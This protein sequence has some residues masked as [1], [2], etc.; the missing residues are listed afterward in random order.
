MNLEDIKKIKAGLSTPKPVVKNTG[1]SLEQLILAA[2]AADQKRAKQVPKTAEEKAKEEYEKILEAFNKHTEEVI[3]EQLEIKPWKIHDP[4]KLWDVTKDEEIEYFDP[5]LSYELTGY[6]PITETEGL[7]FDPKEFTKAADYYLNHGRYNDLVPNTFKW[8]NFWKEEFNKCLNGV[9]IGKYTLTGQN[10]FF[11][12]YYRLLSP[13]K[14]KED[15]GSKRSESFPVF[16]AKQ[17]EYF[18]YLEMCKRA[19]FDGLA[20][21]SRGVDIALL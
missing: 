12:N 6:R 19:E 7:D 17:Y 14:K 8:I 4:K 3:Q 13:L 1:R 18:H 15:N 21:K 11:L 20:F 9:T 10:Y 5:T 16:I 2:N